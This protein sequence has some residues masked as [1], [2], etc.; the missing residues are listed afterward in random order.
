MQVSSLSF[1][2][3]QVFVILSSEEVGTFEQTF[4][5]NLVSL[6]IAAV[7]VRRENLQVFQEI[8]RGGWALWGRSFFGFLGIVLF[9]YAAGH[10]RQAEVAMLNRASP[11]F[12]TLLAGIFLKEKITPVKIAST[13]LCL[14]G[15]YI[16]RQPSFDSNPFPLLAALLAAGLL[17][18]CA[19]SA[20]TAPAQEQEPEQTAAEETA[21]AAQPQ[22]AA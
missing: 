2:I 16:A 1:S 9:F 6:I 18:L 4:F 22:E 3:M 8:K 5:R 13:I 19:C 11:V 15:A 17:V 10:A 20:K 14:V 21:P 12:V 7:M